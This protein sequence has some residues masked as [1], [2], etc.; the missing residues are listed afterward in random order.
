M[1]ESRN[2]NRRTHIMGHV[3]TKMI[4]IAVPFLLG[5]P[6]GLIGLTAAAAEENWHQFKYDC[7]HSGNVPDRSVTTPLGLIGAVPLTDAIFTAPVVADE[8]I[9]VVDG[10]GVA[11]C[12]DAAT[13]QVVWKFPTRGGKANCNNISSPA[14][15]V[16]GTPPQGVPKRSPAW[17][18]MRVGRA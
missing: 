3:K 14:I 17:A 7:R 8:R 16:L 18:G 6:D 4:L 1:L 2:E 15:V 10:A 13:L 11:F 5:S 12:I 9:Y